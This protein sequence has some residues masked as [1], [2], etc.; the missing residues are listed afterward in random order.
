M[1][2][3]SGL[4]LWIWAFVLIV[5]GVHPDALNNTLHA[6]GARKVPCPPAIDRLY[7]SV[8][9]RKHCHSVRGTDGRPCRW[10]SSARCV[11]GSPHDFVR[12][13]VRSVRAVDHW[14]RGYAD[15]WR[16]L[17][18]TAV[19]A[20]RYSRCAMSDN[21]YS[22]K[23]RAPPKGQMLTR[24]PKLAQVFALVAQMFT[25]FP[26]RLQLAFETLWGLKTPGSV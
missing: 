6:R 14:G 22:V 26:Q 1:K 19:A 25:R 15:L 18:A 17:G 16:D 24:V 3:V 5:A 2:P 4:A 12:D 10:R 13:A 9:E 8:Q 23:R 21:R 7:G 20:W 11:C